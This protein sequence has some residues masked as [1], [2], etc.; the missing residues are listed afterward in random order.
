MSWLDRASSTPRALA[1]AAIF[2]RTDCPE[3]GSSIVVR[4]VTDRLF[5][6]ACRSTSAVPQSFWE[7]VCFR[8]FVA[9][10]ARSAVRLSLSTAMTAEL[11]LYV[12]FA[13]QAPC[14]A[15]C[16]TPLP[17]APPGTDLL[18]ACPGCGHGT[19]VMAAP[20]WLT[21]DFPDLVQFF[22]P[23]EAPEVHAPTKPIS[24]GCTE[25][26][27]KLALT[28]GMPRI[29]ECRYCQA[30]IF[31]PNDLWFAVNPVQ[32]RRAWWVTFVR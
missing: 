11:P 21:K 22:V 30:S 15:N 7:G 18:M 5:C 9:Y 3:C 14:C 6:T 1:S 16:A 19:H 27:G 17:S 12:R 32:K 23:A 10:P 29:L 8:L 4:G 20:P 31:L 13:E 25:C 2:A 24:F 28:T 26:G